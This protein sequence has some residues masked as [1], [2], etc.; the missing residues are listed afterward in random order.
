MK[1]HSLSIDNGFFSLSVF[2][3][4]LDVIFYFIARIIVVSKKCMEVFIMAMVSN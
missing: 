4:F 2:E 1:I 3:S